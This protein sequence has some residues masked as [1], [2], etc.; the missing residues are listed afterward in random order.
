MKKAIAWQVGPDHKPQRLAPG[1]VAL[2]KNLENWVDQDIDIVADDV[3]IIG[4]QLA[5]AWGTVLDLLGI[6][7]EGD[8]V[9][10]ELKRDQTLRETIA[11]GLEYAAWAHTQSPE[12]VMQLGATRFNDEE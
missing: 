9:I 8:L 11:Q 3:L 10:I 7:A 2:E 4:R 5:T 12:A 1:A 6:N